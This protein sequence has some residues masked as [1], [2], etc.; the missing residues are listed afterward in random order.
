MS[1]CNI[2]I[3]VLGGGICDVGGKTLYL[4]ETFFDSLYSTA[5]R[6]VAHS[7]R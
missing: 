2:Y 4:L 6:S 7:N 3:L 5:W 1:T